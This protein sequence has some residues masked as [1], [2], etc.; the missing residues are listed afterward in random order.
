MAFSTTILAQDRQHNYPAPVVT[1]DCFRLSDLISHG[2]IHLN[3]VWMGGFKCI[4]CLKSIFSFNY[5]IP[6]ATAF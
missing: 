5:L 2:N 1:L 6:S 3:Q 4:H